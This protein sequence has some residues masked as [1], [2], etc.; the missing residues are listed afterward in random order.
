[1]AQ[2]DKTSIT[3]HLFTN[4]T[5]TK[6]ATTGLM[7]YALVQA[8]APAEAAAYIEPAVSFLGLSPA[9]WTMVGAIAA[10]S[11]TAICIILALPRLFALGVSVVNCLR[12]R[13]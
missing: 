6:G 8:H 12:G 2:Q 13:K 4:P 7:G 5:P 11:Y 9:E 3:A 1:M 10:F